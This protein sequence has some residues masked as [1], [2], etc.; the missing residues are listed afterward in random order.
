MS[1]T[2]LPPCPLGLTPDDLSAWRDHTL[3]PGEERRVAAHIAG[4][5]ACGRTLDA[6]EAL[7]A[8]LAAEQ[9]PAPDPRNWA[10]LQARIAAARPLAPAV[11]RRVTPQRR[12]AVWSGLS[13]V[14]AVLLLSALFFHLLDQQAALRAGKSAHKTEPAPTPAPLLA[15]APTAPIAGPRLAWATRAAP[16]S[17]VPPPGNQSLTNGIAFAPSDPQ[18]AYICSAANVAGSNPV[19][20]WATHDGAATWTHVT[21]LPNSDSVAQCS[22]TVDAHAP[23]RLNLFISGQNNQTLKSEVPSYVSRDGGKTWRSLN[24]DLQLVGLSTAGQVS[25]AV[26][27]PLDGLLSPV[28]PGQQLRMPRLVA[29]RDDFHSWAPIDGQF[30]AQGQFVSNVWQRPSDGALLAQ[31]ET[32]HALTATPTATVAP[33]PPAPDHYY[34]S[35]LWQSAD[36]GAHWEPFPTPA[37]LAN[38]TTLYDMAYLVAEPLGGAPWK[39]CGVSDVSKRSAATQQ[40]IGCTLDSG[41]TWTSRPLPDLKDSCGASCVEGQVMGGVGG[42]VLADGSLISA[43]YST[44]AA[45]GYAETQQSYHLYRLPAGASQ[46]QDLGS[47]PGGVTIALSSP[48]ASTFVSFS[49]GGSL[50]GYSGSI[51]GQ[52]GGDV[53]NRGELAYATLS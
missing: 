43:F 4:C 11:P 9:P 29:S 12:A 22:I 16:A 37:N 7:A 39:V 6:H 17:V 2:H 41:K 45:N 31:V 38:L 10:R 28:T 33:G 15:V 40:I 23:E 25:V 53:P 14:A 34:T 48:S 36:L 18:T 1:A 50:D 44:S 51:V 49:G 5:A 19:A 30:S 13:A 3:P 52:L 26:A 24:D 20:I 8:A 32:R 46:W 47:A 21:D 27:S 35:A 42:H